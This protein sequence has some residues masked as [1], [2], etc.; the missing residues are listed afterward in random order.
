MVSSFGFRVSGFVFR[1]SSFK[2]RVSG[3][4]FRVSSFGFRVTVSGSSFVIRDSGSGFGIREAG[5]GIRDSVFSISGFRI[6]GFSGIRDLGCTGERK[7]S[8]LC[9]WSERN[10]THT[11]TRSGAR[12]NSNSCAGTA[13]CTVVPLGGATKADLGTRMGGAAHVGKIGQQFWIRHSGFGIRVSSLGCTGERKRS[14]LC[15]W[16]ERNATQ[17]AAGPTSVKTAL[18]ERTSSVFDKSSL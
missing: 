3:F 17:S 12:S 8:S 7:R 9:G 13:S 6:R 11:A 14:S 15:G 2:L 10:A 5:F 16:S 1:V 18:L 4:E